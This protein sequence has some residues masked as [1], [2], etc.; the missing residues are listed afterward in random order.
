M[1]LGISCSRQELD[2]MLPGDE[3]VGE[4]MTF[5]AH[6][7]ENDE[8]RT[9]FI[10]DEEPDRWPIHW[11][12]G[13]AINIFYG[14][15]SSA[16]FETSEEL[17]E[18]ASRAEFVGYLQAATGVA[19]ESDGGSTTQ[20]F[21]A[22]YPYDENNS[23]DGSSVTLT[24]PSKQPGVA[25]TFANNLNPTVAMSPNLGLA[26]YNVGSW[27]I[28]SLTQEGVVSATLEGADGETLVGKVQVSMDSNHHPHIDQVTEGKR[29]VTM[30]PD[31]DSF[32]TGQFY[33][34]VILPG[35]YNN[36]FVLTL[37]KA[38]GSKATCNVKHQDGTPVVLE[39]SKWARKKKADEGLV[40]KQTPQLGG[41][42]YV[43]M[44][45]GV[46]WATMNVGATSLTDPGELLDWYEAKAAIATW[47]ENWRLPTN[48][49]LQS[50]HDNCTWTWDGARQGFTVT[51]TNGNSIFLP[52][53]GYVDQ[54]NPSG[55]GTDDLGFYW[56]S[57]YE[58]VEF[59]EGQDP[60]FGDGSSEIRFSVRPVVDK[61]HAIITPTGERDG[62]EYVDMGNGFL[63][64]TMNVG[65]TSLTDR[66][67]MLSKSDAKAAAEAWGENWRLPT[68]AELQ[69]LIDNCTWTLVGTGMIVTSTSNGNSIFLP[70]TGYID[71]VYPEGM[72]EN[73][74]GFYWSSSSGDDVYLEFENGH[75][76][77]DHPSDSPYLRI[78][79][80]PIVDRIHAIITPTG[81]MDGH[82]YVDMG[83]G[84]KW[85]TRNVGATSLTDP[86]DLLTCYA[87]ETAA[88]AWGENWRLPTKEELDWLAYFCTWTW[89]AT[90]KGM[91]VKSTNGNSIFFPVAGYIDDEHPS[92]FGTNDMGFYWSTFS[93]YHLSFEDVG[94]VMV[95]PGGGSDMYMSV[96]PVVDRIQVTPS[97]VD[98][99]GDLLWAT[100][101][102]GANSPEHYGN[103]YAWG[104][105]EVKNNYDW[106]RYKFGYLPT[107]YQ[108]NGLT[109]LES[110]DDVAA[111]KWGGSWRMP[112]AEDWQWLKENCEWVETRN[113][114]GTGVAG[115]TVTATNGNSIF[116]PF[117][118]YFSG[119]SE[120]GLSEFGSSGL[121]WSS[122]LGDD[123][124]VAGM[125]FFYSG[126]DEPFVSNS[127]RC[128]GLTIRPVSPK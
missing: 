25:G 9:A 75:I 12:P 26:F 113:Y 95:G 40:Y 7:G 31:G 16:R 105:T 44:G 6:F 81:E 85:A 98:M 45:N 108:P 59:E 43:D 4:K 11:L 5:E 56:S 80:R 52:V 121:Y 100:F 89:D 63:W 15:K 92:G 42:E 39:R 18:A 57:T 66:G 93:D 124:A 88:A 71:D 48:E 104:E 118:G 86:G 107:K 117:A 22:V 74:L 30:S 60:V 50:L 70:F 96:R 83:N 97:G 90:N 68:E 67:D 19:D 76:S 46:M 87:G 17:T 20:N 3:T 78:S 65:A 24:I 32:Q 28:F 69:S 103:Y 84:M 120:F 61:V 102:V 111:Q 123:S 79:V 114:N 82:E 36:G 99:G 77:V 115:F 110:S 51:S 23:C 112:T 55:F 37:T 128:E 27:F 127:I 94:D 91:I 116:L 13:D 125:M 53:A 34:M 58:Y 49:E 29:F 14:S 72:G 126:S 47:G 35:T 106:D 101:N 41:H 73:Y 2:V 1:L 64:A 119:N 109:V 8:T 10:S 38:D 33:C 62:H 21:W 54:Y 122:T